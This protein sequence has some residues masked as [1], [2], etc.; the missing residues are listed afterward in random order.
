VTVFLQVV[1]RYVLGLA[2]PWTEEAARYF[3][4][5]MVFMGCS[6]AVAREGHIRVTFLIQQLRGVVRDIL[7]VALYVVMAGFEVIVFFGAIRLTQ[8]NWNQQATTLPVTVST[9]YIALIVSALFSFLFVV[10]LFGRKLTAW[11]G[12]RT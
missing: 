9:L 3:N 11:V 1:F 4:V 8:L 2:V 12:R 7:L 10:F 5:W 6:V